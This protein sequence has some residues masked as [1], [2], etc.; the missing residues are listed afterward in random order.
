MPSVEV[1]NGNVVI[2]L[3]GMNRL[4]AFTTQSQIVVPVASISSVSQEVPDHPWKTL[5]APGTGVP[6]HFYA[7]TFY[8]PGTQ[9][10]TKEFWYHGAKG[11]VL[12]ISTKAGVPYDRIAVSG[13]AEE[14]LRWIAA[15]QGA[16]AQK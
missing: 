12:T 15:V 9:K 6:G 14:T 13:S 4:W 1:Q 11:P 3:T 7:G 16:V 2:S 5:R 10:R 8:V